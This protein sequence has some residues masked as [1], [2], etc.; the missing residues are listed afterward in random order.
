M[1][2]HF[3]ELIISSIQYRS[4]RPKWFPAMANKST[5]LIL[6]NNLKL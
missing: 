4:P 1:K 5:V 2:I 3:F 6:H